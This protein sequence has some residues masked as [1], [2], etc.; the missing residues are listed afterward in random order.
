[1]GKN[2]ERLFSF[3]CDETTIKKINYI[4]SYNERDRNKEIKYLI[5]KEIARFEKEHGEIETSE[6]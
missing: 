2:L 6:Q 1:M 3:R 4:A 5:K